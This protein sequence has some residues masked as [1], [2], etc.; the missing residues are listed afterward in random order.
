MQAKLRG[1]EESMCIHALDAAMYDE[2]HS[3]FCESVAPKA[4][5]LDDDELLGRLCEKFEC[6]SD[7]ISCW[8]PRGQIYTDYYHLKE[9]IH[10][11][12]DESH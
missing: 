5:T 12:L 6:K 9:G 1:D 2:A 7:R 4:V 8:G 11:I 3:L 10:E